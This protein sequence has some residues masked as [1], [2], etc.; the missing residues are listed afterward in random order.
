MLFLFFSTYAWKRCRFHVRVGPNV[1]CARCV[2][3]IVIV[4]FRR[5]RGPGRYYRRSTT[6]ST[7]IEPTRLIEYQGRLKSC[8]TYKFTSSSFFSNLSF[9]LQTSSWSRI[10]CSL[11]AYNSAFSRRSASFSV[12]YAWINW[13]SSGRSISDNL[14]RSTTGGVN[15]TFLSAV[16]I[17]LK[18]M[19]TRDKD[20]YEFFSFLFSFFNYLWIRYELYLKRHHSNEEPLSGVRFPSE[21]LPLLS[22]S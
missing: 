11:V 18:I 6:H 13:L 2:L 15:G 20:F 3:V 8:P 19:K 1:G 7:V 10:T 5:I 4:H 16:K 17:Y 22:S 12:M 9:S 21:E 14:S